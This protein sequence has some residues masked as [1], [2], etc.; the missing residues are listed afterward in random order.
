MCNITKLCVCVHACTTIY[1]SSQILAIY[2][3]DV[4]K[5]KVIMHGRI[6]I[7]NSGDKI[8]FI[9]LEYVIQIYLPSIFQGTGVYW[10]YQLS[11]T[12][13]GNQRWLSMTPITYNFQS[14]L[15]FK[16]WYQGEYCGSIR[17]DMNSIWRHLW[18]HPVDAMSKAYLLKL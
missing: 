18:A 11:H 9:G 6:Y 3:K 1:H 15:L 8:P 7:I 13:C 10:L 14:L 2:I 17:G 12:S 4:K 16:T 5:T